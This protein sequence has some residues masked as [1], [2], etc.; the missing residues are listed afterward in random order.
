MKACSRGLHS[1]AL[2][3]SATR[4]GQRFLYRLDDGILARDAGDVNRFSGDDVP[5]ARDGRAQARIRCEAQGADFSRPVRL[6][7]SLVRPD[8]IDAEIPEKH[9]ANGESLGQIIA[10]TIANEM[11]EHITIHHHQD[12]GVDEQSDDVDR[13][14]LG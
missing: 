1:L 9:H 6:F 2:R 11:T 7:D 10:Q 13:G 8:A 5:Q 3:A 12:D 4:L 14:E